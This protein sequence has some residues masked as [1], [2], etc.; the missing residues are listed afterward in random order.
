MLPLP[1]CCAA[2]V[3]VEDLGRFES[4]CGQ[5]DVGASRC[6]RPEDKDLIVKEVRG[7]VQVE[8][9]CKGGVVGPGWM[10]GRAAVHDPRTKPSQ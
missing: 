2:D 8:G 9:E 4:T 10:W 3:S 1:P 7:R 5:M 6:A